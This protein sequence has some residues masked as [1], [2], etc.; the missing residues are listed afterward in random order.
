VAFRLER[1]EEIGPQ[2]RALGVGRFDIKCVVLTH[3]HVAHEGGLAP[4]PT[5]DILVSP[6]ELR[7]ARGLLGRL[8]GY[9][10][11]RWPAWFDPKP[12]DLAPEVFGSVGATQTGI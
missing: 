5:T 11:N 1:E 2:L 3:L 10:P 7:A 6:G 4:F 8:R 9:L 12:L